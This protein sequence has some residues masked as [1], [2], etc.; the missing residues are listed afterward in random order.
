MKNSR[1]VHILKTFSKKEV[2]E[3]SKWLDSPAHNQRD[4]V[5]LLFNFLTNRNRLQ[6][7]KFSQKEL[8]KNSIYFC[9][10]ACI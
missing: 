8:Q 7:D 4:D 2:R 1:L 6:K 3:F 10:S 9:Q 5:V